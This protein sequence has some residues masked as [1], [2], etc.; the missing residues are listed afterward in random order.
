M[1]KP[2]ST[3]VL[4]RESGT[5]FPSSLRISERGRLIPEVGTSSSSAGAGS[6]SGLSRGLGG[7]ALAAKERKIV[8]IPGRGG[9]WVDSLERRR[10]WAELAMETGD[11]SG[12]V[13]RELLAVEVWG[14]VS[15]IDELYGKKKKKRI[16]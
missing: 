5:L 7:E 16:Y 3:R 14:G 15:D 12:L 11:E 13:G 1:E 10:L 6:R 4:T 9:G 2:P 8:R